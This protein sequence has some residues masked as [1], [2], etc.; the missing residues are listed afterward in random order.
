MTVDLEQSF[1]FPCCGV[2]GA[3]AGQPSRV[4]LSARI[5]DSGLGEIFF[6]G[7]KYTVRSSTTIMELMQGLKGLRARRSH[8]CRAASVPGRS[9]LGGAC[10]AEFSGEVV[11]Q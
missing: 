10:G 4:L 1:R 3:L 5:I 2:S 9:S 11:V 7:I 8:D 6:F